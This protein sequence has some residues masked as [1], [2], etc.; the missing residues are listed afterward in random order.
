MVVNRSD[1]RRRRVVVDPAIHGNDVL[2]MSPPSERIPSKRESSLYAT[3]ANRRHQYKTTDLIPKRV[4][5]V[6]LVVLLL[7]SV[8]VGLNLLSYF[9]SRW[10]D[11]IGSEGVTALSLTG[12]ATLTAWFS[13]FL[14]IVSGLASLQIYALRQHRRDDY[15][16]SYRLWLWMSAL[17]LI[18][19]A[20]CVVDLASIGS[21][22]MQSLTTI[23]FAANSW[24]PLIVKLSLLSLLVARGVYEVRES[25]GSLALVV[26]VWI[27]YSAA[28]VMQL[29]AV[30][31]LIVSVDRETILGNGCLIGSLAT[32]L[33]EMTFAR[34]VF[35]QAHGLIQ[36]RAAT[37]SKSKAETAVGG[38]L[39]KK[40]R[41][42]TKANP[43]ESVE[44]EATESNSDQSEPAAN[45]RTASS[46]RL[47]SKSER[48]D[49]PPQKSKT[50]LVDSLTD[51]DQDESEGILKLG[52]SEQRRLRKQDQGRRRAA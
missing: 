26:L 31:P 12:R 3:G 51:E 48:S 43:T 1:S 29:P 24:W 9:A 42:K 49:R 5:P 40:P 17:L 41:K 32:L 6:S 21:R 10:S 45:Q 27:A 23:S 16:G 4:W 18:G 47:T 39:T 50:A 36:P 7:V 2:A 34:F 22:L 44:T 13:S 38:E 11:R 14:L 19:S 28:A 46:N 20:N 35:L 30:E 52:K 8:I 25:R 33:V 37:I 15:R